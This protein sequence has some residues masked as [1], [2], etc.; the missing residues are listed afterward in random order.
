MVAAMVH[1]PCV[2]RIFDSETKN[3]KM[4]QSNAKIQYLSVQNAKR[5]HFQRHQELMQKWPHAASSLLCY[6]DYDG[7]QSDSSNLYKSH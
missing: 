7:R 4:K 3:N 1:V 2:R 6:H 5:D